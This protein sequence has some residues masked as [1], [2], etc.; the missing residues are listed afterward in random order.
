MSHYPSAEQDAS[1]RPGHASVLPPTQL[2]HQQRHHPL[3]QFREQIHEHGPP[4]PARPHPSGG[5][6]LRANF[7]D[8]VQH[9]Y[10]RA[11][12]NLNRSKSLT[13]PERQR[14][15]TGMIKRTTSIRQQAAATTST[16]AASAAATAGG[17][18][19]AGGHGG[20][21]IHHRTPFNNANYNGRNQPMS[22]N[23][24]LQLQQQK[25]QQQLMNNIGGAQSVIEEQEPVEKEPSPLN[26]WWAWIAF[27]CTCCIP[28]Y[29]IRVWGRKPNKNMQQAWREKVRKRTFFLALRA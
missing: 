26:N 19:G 17:G 29:I 2:H 5:V 6:G 24:Q 22:N 25:Q 8:T 13:R 21:N 7:D 14:P 1:T 15:R 27:L 3:P 10:H 18:G 28:N 23:L 4:Q 11:T 12:A 9:P 20:D 16:A